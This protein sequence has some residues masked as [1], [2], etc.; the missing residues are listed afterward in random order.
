LVLSEEQ[1]NKILAK[2]EKLVSFC[3]R[4][5][6]KNFDLS[7]SISFFPLQDE[8][9]Q[10]ETVRLTMKFKGRCIPFIVTT[11]ENCGFLSL[12]SLRY[13]GFMKEGDIVFG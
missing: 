6:N 9:F 8:A 4:C 13:L 2:L 7:S 10:I 5:G 3:P 1:A 12:H 11:C